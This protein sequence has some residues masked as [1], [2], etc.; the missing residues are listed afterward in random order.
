MVHAWRLGRFHPKTNEWMEFEAPPPA[1]FTHK[2]QA[3]S[4]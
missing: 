4:L 3:D 2:L 1:D